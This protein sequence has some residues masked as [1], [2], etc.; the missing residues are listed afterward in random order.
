MLTKVYKFIKDNNLISQGDT[1]VCGLSGGADSV[2]LLICMCELSSKLKINVEALHV[3]HCLRAAESDGDQQFCQELCQKLNV[4]F[5][6]VSCDV[7]SYAFEHSLSTEEA[8]RVL[9]YSIF[10]EHSEGKSLPLLIM[11]MTILKQ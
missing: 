10:N 6:A 4:P 5:L 2:A 3:N 11:Q 8:A 9:R 7:N 1:I